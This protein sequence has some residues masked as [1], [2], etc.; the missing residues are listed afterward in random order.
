VLPLLPLLLLLLLLLLCDT[1]TLTV[2]GFRRPALRE[3]RKRTRPFGLLI[4]IP[5]ILLFRM[6]LPREFFHFLCLRG[7]E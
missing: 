5:L 2:T 1:M 7:G 3:R 6:G 4:S